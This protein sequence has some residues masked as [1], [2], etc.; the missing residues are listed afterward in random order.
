MT[1]ETIKEKIRRVTAEAVSLSEYDPQWPDMF[2]SEKKHLLCCMPQDFIIRIEHFG[3][4]SVPGLIA[5]PVIDMIIEITN[6]DSGRKLIPKILEPQGYDCFWRP[7]GNINEPPFFTWC[8]KRNSHGR[9]THH[10][11][12]VKPGFKNDELRFR[13]ILRANTDLA[14]EYAKLKK[15]LAEQ[16]SSDRISYTSGKGEFIKQILSMPTATEHS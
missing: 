11:H 13:D 10:L 5:K 6:E 12:F 7:L 16:Y 1:K 15:H 8:I 2:I 9:R 4:T 3:S 14:F